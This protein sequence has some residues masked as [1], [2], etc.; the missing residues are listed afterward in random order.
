[1]GNFRRALASTLFALLSGLAVPQV[2]RGDLPAPLTKPCEKL[3]TVTKAVPVERRGP[4]VMTF[5]QFLET[6]GR[7]TPIPEYT[8]GATPCVA[9]RFKVG[10]TDVRMTSGGFHKE[11]QTLY[12]RILYEGKTETH[13]ILVLYNGMVSAVYGDGEYFSVTETRGLATSF[14]EVYKAPP[15]H[16]ALKAL[17]TK[18]INGTAKPLIAGEFR[19]D[20]WEFYITAYDGDRLTSGK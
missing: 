11:L 3:H 8:L 14:Y 2:A 6:Q 18:I 20:D 19:E 5:V 4:V 16:A 15:D 17:A 10:D 7:E 13:K 12:Y 1:M 9:E